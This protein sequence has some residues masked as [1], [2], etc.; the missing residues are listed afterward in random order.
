MAR[1]HPRAALDLVGVNCEHIDAMEAET[2][3]TILVQARPQFH[4]EHFELRSGKLS[5]LKE[6]LRPI[7]KGQKARVPLEDNFGADST[8]ALAVVDG[9][10]VEV[11]HA[12]DRVGQEVE[13]RITEHDRAIR[14]A[15][16]LR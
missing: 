3:K 6:R 9:N 16:V 2:S 8:S 14:K 7:H 13:I 15:E 12:A 1:L 5:E 11:L 4:V 10:L